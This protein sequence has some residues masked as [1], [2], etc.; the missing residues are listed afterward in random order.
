MQ[1]AIGT[2]PRYDIGEQAESAYQSQVTEV[3]NSLTA[4]QGELSAMRHAIQWRTASNEAFFKT[5]QVALENMPARLAVLQECLHGPGSIAQKIPNL[6]QW[7]VIQGS[8]EQ[9]KA[10]SFRLSL[11]EKEVKKLKPYCTSQTF[12]DIYLYLA[13]LT[14]DLRANVA[15]SWKTP[16]EAHAYLARK[17]QSLH[18]R[19]SYLQQEAEIKD[20]KERRK[21]F[22]SKELYLE[23]LKVTRCAAHIKKTA[24][25]GLDGEIAVV[26]SHLEQLMKKPI[27]VSPRDG[28]TGIVAVYN[29]D[30]YFWQNVPRTT[31]VSSTVWSKYTDTNE[32][33]QAL[34]DQV[35]QVI[36][37]LV[38]LLDE[39]LQF[40]TKKELDDYAHHL[41]ELQKSLTALRDVIYKKSYN[42]LT[43]YLLNYTYG[44]QYAL[45]HCRSLLKIAD[46][47]ADHPGNKAVND[48]ARALLLDAKPPIVLEALRS[49]QAA[50]VTV[51]AS[52]N[53]VSRTW[54][55]IL[56]IVHEVH[57]RKDPARFELTP[58]EATACDT[59]L[60]TYSVEEL[61][62]PDDE[63]HYLPSSLTSYLLKRMMRYILQPKIFEL[64]MELELVLFGLS[65]TDRLK[66][67]YEQTTPLFAGILDDY[68]RLVVER[69]P[70]EL[71][72]PAEIMFQILQAQNEP[73]IRSL[74]LSW[75][76]FSQYINGPHCNRSMQEFLLDEID[77]ATRA[78]NYSLYLPVVAS[79]SLADWPIDNPAAFFLELDRASVYTRPWMQNVT[80]QQVFESLLVCALASAIHSSSVEAH[81]FIMD[82][83]LNSAYDHLK[84]LPKMLL[85]LVMDAAFDKLATCS[86]Q[87]R[88]TLPISPFERI[89]LYAPDSSIDLYLKAPNV[90]KGMDSVRFVVSKILQ[91][92]RFLPE[93]DRVI[94]I[95]FR[96]YQSVQFVEDWIS[97][98]AHLQANDAVLKELE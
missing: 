6:P 25:D 71:G 87:T 52:Q 45:S 79:K 97:Q 77:A 44:L 69:R 56:D 23:A 74:A 86:F 66:P 51:K 49:L 94:T 26:E 72:Q 10:L 7:N 5:S 30:Y 70:E 48:L 8:I 47:L 67:L 81:L 15:E 2:F 82:I 24:L 68:E 57:A 40:S 33:A 4:L 38:R 29:S 75:H 78:H 59:L 91:Q 90:T 96:D 31:Q 65:T 84:Y 32:H 76:L 41:V 92:E 62:E 42:S 63:R 46:K 34:N 89:L 39:G 16:D 58:E 9:V 35:G 1:G 3:D 93:D 73:N 28:I 18:V 54:S 43:R 21:F 83:F 17:L 85:E 27:Q 80:R 14:E 20:K 37:N 55:K 60:L 95:R 12:R 50:L 61:Y 88:A 13:E 98:H 19:F 36:G 22:L 11:A 64:D 53:L